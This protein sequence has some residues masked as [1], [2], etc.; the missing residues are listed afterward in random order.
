MRP[1]SIADGVL[2][3]IRA[4][5]QQAAEDLPWWVGRV[6]GQR[7]P[8]PAQPYS[9]KNHTLRVQWLGNAHGLLLGTYT[10]AWIVPET[11]RRFFADRATN[12]AAPYT[13]SYDDIE[14]VAKNVAV[15]SFELKADRKIPK[16]VL[17]QLSSDPGLS[18][19]LPN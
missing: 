7:R 12:E 9:P 19:R 17:H 15:H 16:A 2:V 18:W 1:E 10:P 4:P 11:R 6:I 14:I 3:V 5:V 8:S 13:N